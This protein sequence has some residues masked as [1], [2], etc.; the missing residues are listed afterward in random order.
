M[1]PGS[2]CYLD[3]SQSKN[4]DSVTIG[5]YLS[6]G[7]VYSYEPIPVSLNAEQA[8]HIL[9][10]QGNL[11]TEYISNTSKLEYMIFPRMIALS[12]VLWS[13]REKRDWKDFEKRLPSTLERLDKQKINYSKSY[14]EINESV[15]P[16][17]NQDALIQHVAG[18]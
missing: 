14:D 7:K 17:K 16:T 3:H 4:E 12:E 6:L 2:H 8:K 11:W 9:G 18:I 5:G 1:T 15:L 10:A 13:P